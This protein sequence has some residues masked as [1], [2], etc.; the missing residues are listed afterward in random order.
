MKISY[1]SETDTLYIDLNS[2]V[3]T[4][5]A[6]V[7][8]DVAVDLDADGNLVRVEIEH[9]SRRVDLSRLDTQSLPLTGLSLIGKS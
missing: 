9:A 2:A 4:D 1:Y 5:T 8:P 6:K 3:G 7:A